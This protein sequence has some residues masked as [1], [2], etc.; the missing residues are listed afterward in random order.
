[1]TPVKKQKGRVT[2]QVGKLAQD[3]K[4]AR[5]GQVLDKEYYWDNELKKWQMRPVDEERKGQPM[6]RASF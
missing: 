4:N 6:I 2:V 1:M 5:Y 3:Q